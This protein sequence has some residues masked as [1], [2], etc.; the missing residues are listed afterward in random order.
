M[1]LTDSNTA[2]VVGGQGERQQL[3]KDSVWC[4]DTGQL[5]WN[6]VQNYSDLIFDASLIFCFLFFLEGRGGGVSPNCSWYCWYSMML[7]VI[8]IVIQKIFIHWLMCSKI[9]L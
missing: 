9:I 6:P 8:E 2:V 7:I 1:C 3:S 4:L 5:K